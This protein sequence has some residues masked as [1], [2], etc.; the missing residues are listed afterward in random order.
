MNNIFKNARSLWVKY[1]RYEWKEDNTATLFLT[2]T[3]DAELKLYNPMENYREMILDALNVGMLCMNEDTDKGE[4][5]NKILSFVESYG[6]LGF[7]TALPTTPDFIT[8]ESVYLPK[9]HY[10]KKETL[11]TQEFLSYFF[12]FEEICFVKKK[13]ESSWSVT[14]TKMGALVLTLRNMPQAV[15][16][17]FQKEYAERLDWL[18]SAFSDLAFTFFSSFLYYQDFAVLDEDQKDLYRKGMAAFGGVAPTYHMELRDKPVIVWEFHSLLLQLQ[19]MLSLMITDEDSSIRVC[20]NCGRAFISRH[21][22]ANYCSKEC[23]DEFKNN[24]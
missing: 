17:S 3:T 7:M 21:S 4:I 11:S 9:N 13:L 8:Y 19:M 18:I 12:P 22:N 23:K 14:D 6:L 5:R 15:L 16:M 24:K 20:K 1:D 10:I 2:P